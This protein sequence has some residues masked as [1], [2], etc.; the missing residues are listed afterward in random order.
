MRTLKESIRSYMHKVTFALVSVILV[1]VLVLNIANEQSR[2]Q[3]TADKIFEQMDKI[4]EEN[5][6]ELTRLRQE[7]TAECLHNTE[8]IA[9]ILEKNPAARYNRDELRKI[10]EFMEVD[11]IHIIDARGEIVS[12][13]HPQYYGYNFDSGEQMNFFK[14]MLTDKFL[15]MV[16]DIEPNTAEQKLMQ[17]SAMW[18]STGEFIVEVGIEPVNVSKVTEKNELPYI[19]S[20][21]CVNPDTSYF[22]ID[23]QT[24]K[25]VGATDAELVGMDMEAVG[26]NTE[27]IQSTKGFS[28]T[29]NGKRSYTVFKKVADN[30]IGVAVTNKA[31]YER[32]PLNMLYLV[33]CLGIIALALFKAVTRYM[34][35]DVVQKIG[36]VNGKLYKITMG[37]L[38]AKVDVHSTK[39]FSELSRYINEMLQSL[40]VNDRKMTYV[41]GKTD[42][43][44][45]VYEYNKQMKKVRFTGD[46]LQILKIGTEDVWKLT[47][48]WADFKKY[49]GNMQKEPV[50]GENEIFAV[51]NGQYLRIE[52][53][54][55]GEEIFGVVTDVTEEI[56]KRKEIEYDRDHDRL[57]GLYNRR[58][59]E[60]RLSQ[61]L[62]ECREPY[63]C[64]EVMIDADG[65]KMVNDTYGH[66]NGDEYLKQIANVLKQEAGENC[67]L[68]RQGGDEFT[69]FY[70]GCEKEALLQKIEN[71]KA[72][73]S[74]QTAQL[75]DGLTVD[76]KFSM[77]S[78]V[79]YGAVDY[80]KMYREADEKMYEDK[81]T[82]KN[83][84]KE[85]DAKES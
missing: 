63:Y 62:K 28:S 22:A 23:A 57:T 60:F 48:D 54:Q 77:G 30:Y 2:A 42:M 38:N 78:S 40:L 65:L 55:E 79:A 67:I 16:Q 15:K 5:Q 4:L 45:G 70:Y 44:I 50:T 24:G 46:V 37:D 19:F 53:V 11:E 43:R 76:L 68:C 7:Y 80:E 12:G 32:I 14:P 75:K 59:R 52:E 17:Y 72:L 71:L 25:I 3:G 49:I 82:R 31:L 36:E 64:A 34:D 66:E 69:L 20:Q 10:A 58:G 85:T 6:K 8:A 83:L 73:Q 1:S 61:V 51:G 81:R 27:K 35:R 13:T 39:E 74:G 18:N 47:S 84:I 56:R 29:I 9:Y 26:L 21:L 41:L 33:V